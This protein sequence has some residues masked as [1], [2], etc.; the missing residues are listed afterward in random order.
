[1]KK[2]IESDLNR[3]SFLKGGSFA[4]LMTFLGGVEIRP[5]SEPKKPGRPVGPKV[6]CGVIGLGMWGREILGQ[7][8]RIPE[9]EIAMVCD[10]YPIMLKRGASAAPGAT[11]T[12]D[13]RHILDNKEVQAVVVATPTH[14]H[15]EIVLAA[16]QAGKHVYCEAPLGNTLDDARA[17]AVAAKNAPKQVFQSGLQFRSDPQRHFLLGFI[18]SGAMG[19]TIKA[20]AQWHK[21]QSWR[22]SSSNPEREQALNWRLQNGNSLGLAG[23][24][25]IHQ[26]DAGSWFIGGLPS[27]VHGYG[28]VMHWKDGREVPDTVHATFEFPNGIYLDYEATIANSFDS[29]YEIYY[30]T[31]SAIMVRGHKAWLF[32][33]VDSPLL[34]WEVYARKDAFYKETGIA[35]V[36]NASKSTG[37]GAQGADDG[38]VNP[39]VYYALEA[40]LTNV[41]EV[42]TGV[43]DFEAA[44]DAKDTEA[45]LKYLADIHKQP[46]AGYKEGYEATVMAILANEAI[47][48]KQQIPLEKKFFEI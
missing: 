37:D 33:E 11:A 43:E 21:K 38:P 17:I 26:I 5:Q 13:Y 19:N 25:G 1:M 16:L 2:E 39:P 24:L 31:D 20:R 10:H 27:A 6:K 23:E 35:L 18:R 42:K 8:T 30:G 41:N 15:R 4:A 9:A 28:R 22:Y 12:E 48:K 3:R 44:F 46:A 45:L 14:Q 47:L 32:K 36:A 34:G 29:D 40:F 7:L